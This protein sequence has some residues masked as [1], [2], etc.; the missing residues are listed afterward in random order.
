MIGR[1]LSR[2]DIDWTLLVIVLLICG[3]GILQIYSVSHGSDSSAWWRQILYI[4][5]GL[6]L[7][8]LVLPSDTGN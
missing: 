8:W 7:M 3:V 4:L 2:R 5:G 6:F 1:Y